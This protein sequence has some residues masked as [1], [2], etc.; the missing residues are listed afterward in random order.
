LYAPI[1]KRTPLAFALLIAAAVSGQTIGTAARKAGPIRKPECAASAICFAGEVKEGEA[2]RRPINADLEFVLMPGWT[3]AI[4]VR[5]PEGECQE[6]A[7]IVNTPLR[8]HNQL[9]I[10]ASYDWTAEQEVNTSPR[11][12][13]FVTN[14][15]DFEAEYE[16]YQIVEGQLRVSPDKEREALANFGATA[17]GRGRLW[18]TDARTTHEHFNIS[19]ANGAIEWMRFSVEIRLPRN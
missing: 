6:L 18:I 10:D 7:S 17:T 3:I 14:C 12:F 11:E 9:E 5:H 15:R 8:Q 2:F 1:V 16:R 13:V 19:A 4:Y